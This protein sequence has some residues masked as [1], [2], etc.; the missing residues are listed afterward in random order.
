MIPDGKTS[1]PELIGKSGWLAKSSD[2]G[3]STTGVRL[4][5]YLRTF[6]DADRHL[7]FQPFSQWIL[8]GELGVES[9]F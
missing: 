9:I 2:I 5:F 6:G 8:V 4:I 7:G 1:I 3:F